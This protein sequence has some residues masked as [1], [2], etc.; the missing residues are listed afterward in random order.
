MYINIFN[1]YRHILC[2]TI[3]NTTTSSLNIYRPWIGRTNI[4][5]NTAAQ[6]HIYNTV[7]SSNIYL[8]ICIHKFIFF[9]FY[10]LNLISMRIWKLNNLF[11]IL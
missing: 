5:K 1:M 7:C 9:S 8:F 6:E 11:S 10:K 3:S 2:S 4:Y